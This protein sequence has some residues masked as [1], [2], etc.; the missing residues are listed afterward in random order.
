MQSH[1][2]T[3]TRVVAVSYCAYMMARR[4]L[5]CVEEATTTV[6]RRSVTPFQQNAHYKTQPVFLF[7]CYWT[8]L[9]LNGGVSL[10]S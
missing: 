4:A 9:Y 2:T 8:L 7:S 5:Y 1:Y 10:H 6:P 3:S